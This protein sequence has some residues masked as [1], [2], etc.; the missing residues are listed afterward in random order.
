MGESNA[1]R[2][3]FAR[4]AAALIAWLAFIVA[5][6]AFAA[7]HLPVVNHAVLGLAA[8]SPYLM[9][10][11]GVS[12][13]LLL[14]TRRRLA[15]AVAMALFAAS[16]VVKA[17]LFIPARHLDGPSIP[18][19]VLSANV[20]EGGAD[21]PE[22]VAIASADTDLLIAQ[23]VTP[24]FA[25]AVNALDAEF[26]YRMVEAR[27]YANGVGIWSRYPLVQSTRI[28]GYELGA[29]SVTVRVPGAASDVVALVAHLVGPGPQAIDAGRRESAARPDT[30]D[31][32]AAAAGDGAVV[33]AGD[34]NATADMLPFRKL[35]TNGYHDATE[36]AGAGLTPTFP[37]NRSVPPLIGI[38]H[39]LTRNAVATDAATVRIP[40]SDHL[41]ISATV[42]VPA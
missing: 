19:R 10:A 13:L 28:S 31:A 5:G 22:L 39:I 25:A 42:Q 11:S 17:P 37:A 41:A 24:E 36:Q 34:L 40:G 12:A 14:L 23:E 8:M 38:D 15:A 4:A 16:A 30:L 3:R 2:S 33:V 27:S 29:V 32:V 6:V 26:P 9:L 21:A 35:L 7:R 1:A 18:L 20:M